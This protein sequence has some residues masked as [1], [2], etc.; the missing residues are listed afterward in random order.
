VRPETALAQL[1]VVLSGTPPKRTVPPFWDGATAL[2]V[3]S[4]LKGA[5]YRSG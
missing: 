5:A 3:V 2:R 1:Q 4:S